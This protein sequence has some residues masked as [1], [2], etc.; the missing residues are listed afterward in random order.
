LHLLHLTSVS[1][2][3][4]IETVQVQ[5]A[6]HDVQSKFACER[7]SEGSSVTSRCF[8]AD[9]D[10]AMLKGQHVGRSRLMEELPMQR[11]HST[12]RDK[13]DE[14]LAQPGQVRRFPL[15]QPQTGSRC[16]RRELFKIAN[17]HRNGSLP[18]A[19]RDL[20]ACREF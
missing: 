12:I 1:A 17:V 7:I 16:F 19:N 4:I 2:L 10:F 20:Q 5:K 13:P 6:M 14:N 15:A 3:S 9:K 8:N 11:R 18:I